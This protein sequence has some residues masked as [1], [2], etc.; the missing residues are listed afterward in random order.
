MNYR[1]PELTESD[2]LANIHI[3]TFK[4]FFLSELGLSFL[5]TY[6]KAVL[7]YKESIAICAV[8][9]EGEIVGFVTGS[10]HAKGYNTGLIRNNLFS[11]F[12]A[13]LRLLMLNPKSIYRIIKNLEKKSNPADDGNYVELLSIAVL[14]GYKN[15]GVGSQ[16]ITKFEDQAVI[17]GGERITLTTDYDGNE[18]VL[19]F[20]FKNGYKVFYDFYSYPKRRMYK[21]MK[22]LNNN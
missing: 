10:K 13:F 8:N 4:G 5:K 21:L 16:L 11:F 9:D 19:N 22:V 2:V 6:Y 14:P 7:N 12:T 17:D 1:V 18:T 3:N 15:E 20:Y